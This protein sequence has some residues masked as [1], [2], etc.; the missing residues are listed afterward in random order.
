MPA[1]VKPVQF[2]ALLLTALAL[3]PAGAHL[4]ALP[5]K[6][7]LP[8]QS[9]FIVQGI[10][11]GWAQFAVV[12]IAALAANSALA[13][14]VRRQAWP[15][16]LALLAFVCIATMLVVFFV[17]TEPA[18]QATSYWTSA[19]ANWQELR[20]QWEY[21]HAAN[22]FVMLVAFCAVTMSVLTTRA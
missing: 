8:E 16:R 9:Y 11:R 19:P 14:M 12:I 21:S 15:F 10:Y 5:N 2:L 3:V 18:N 22:A 13:F 4:F 17:W 20:T 6:I 1:Y 7:S